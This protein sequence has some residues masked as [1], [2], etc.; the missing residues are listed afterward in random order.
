MAVENYVRIE[1]PLL[2]LSV[3]RSKLFCPKVWFGL[4][5]F[6]KTFALTRNGDFCSAR[7]RS[8][9]VPVA[10]YKKLQEL[11]SDIRIT[12][13]YLSP[14]VAAHGSVPGPETKHYYFSLQELIP[15]KS[16]YQWKLNLEV[17]STQLINAEGPK[18]TFSTDDSCYD[19]EGD[20][21]MIWEKSVCC[22]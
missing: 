21:I 2:T 17:D 8:A 13:E 11:Y 1:G 16:V 5:P 9:E 18:N 7:F 19:G 12:Y 15:L 6:E 4:N 10:F 3:I 20:Y 22:A 14:Q